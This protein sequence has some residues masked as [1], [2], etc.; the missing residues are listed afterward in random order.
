M[1]LNKI[2]RAEVLNI[3]T[4]CICAPYVLRM[5]VVTRNPRL[6]TNKMMGRPNKTLKEVSDITKRKHTTYP[7]PLNLYKNAMFLCLS[8]SYIVRI[9][10]RKS[11]PA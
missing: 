11:T 8:S 7:N 2:A 6:L 1:P 5:T 10:L 4:P 9:A 3:P